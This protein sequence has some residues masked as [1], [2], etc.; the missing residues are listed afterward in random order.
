MTDKSFEHEPLSTKPIVWSIAGSDSCGGAGLQADLSVLQDLGIQGCGIVT[1]VTAQNTLAFY[2]A[3]HSSARMVQQQIEAIKT[4][5]PPRVIKL[6]ALGTAGNIDVIVDYLQNYSGV[7]ICDPVLSATAGGALLE[8][9]AATYLKNS[10]FPLATL[11]TPNIIEAEILFDMKIRC[12]A[13]MEQA[14]RKCLESG[15]KHVL[16]KGGHL[17]HAD[18][19]DYFL[20]ERKGFWLKSVKQELSHQHGTGCTLSAAIAAAVA[21]GYD[22]PDAIVIAK[23]Y[24]NQGLRRRIHIAE[25]H[26]FLAREGWPHHFQDLPWINSQHDG[27]RSRFPKL[28]KRIGLYPI[29][30]SAGW[31]QRLLSCGVSTIQLRLKNQTPDRVQA[32]IRDSIRIAEAYGAQLFIND[33]WEWAMEYGAYGVHLGQSDLLTADL[34]ALQDAGLRVGISTHSFYE[35]A[36]AHAL[37]PSYIAYGPVYETSSKAMVFPPQGLDKLHYWN[38]VLDYPVVAIG[39]IGLQSVQAVCQTGVNGVAVI[40]A[41]TNAENLDTTVREFLDVTQ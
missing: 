40:S 33:Y 10:V 12:A 15:A 21:W 17:D 7:S 13:D 14:A 39:G 29:V 30:D 1:T 20:N 23:M 37:R 24:L 38:T 11:V 19:Q 3:E 32:Q 27:E 34:K 4:A 31:V 22:L 8:A 25:G 41:V 28:K 18:S 36:C 2:Y 9:D 26:H 35:V 5:L 16:L 6:G